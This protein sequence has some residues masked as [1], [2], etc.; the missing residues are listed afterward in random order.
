MKQKNLQSLT[1]DELVK[2]FVLVTLAQ[3][4]ADED[5]PR[6]E[7]L[8][9]QMEEIKNE[10]KNR[11]GDQRRALVN[12]YSHPNMQVRLKAAKA[13]LATSPAAARTELEA[14]ANSGV[15]PQAGEAGMSMWNIDRGIFKPT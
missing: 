15:F 1:V 12:L 7:Q 6:F 13:T 8:F 5:L 10:L 14:I 3:D 11:P 2:Q 9:A 4:E